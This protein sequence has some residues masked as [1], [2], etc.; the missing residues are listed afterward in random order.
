MASWYGGTVARDYGSFGEMQGNKN[1][2]GHFKFTWGYGD[3]GLLAC[4]RLIPP[5]TAPFA[6]SPSQRTCANYRL[7]VACEMKCGSV[8]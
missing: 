8:I 7:F 6:S 5:I 1:E 4:G 3:A 2:T